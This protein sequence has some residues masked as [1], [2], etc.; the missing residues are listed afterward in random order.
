[1]ATKIPDY[2]KF[3]NAWLQYQFVAYNKAKEK[4][5]ASDVYGDVAF[6]KCGRVGTT[7]TKTPAGTVK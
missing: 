2:D 6:R 3:E 7:P 1:M 4:I 5:G